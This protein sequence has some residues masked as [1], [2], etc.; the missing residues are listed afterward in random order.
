M[1]STIM[2]IKQERQPYG[3]TDCAAAWRRRGP[4]PEPMIP[5]IRMTPE[6]L[7]GYRRIS[8]HFTGMEF[9]FGGPSGMFAFY[10][11]F[12]VSAE[13][14]V[15]LTSLL[16]AHSCEH[17]A[18]AME[19][20]IRALQERIDASQ[21]A[22]SVRGGDRL[23]YVWDD[24]KLESFSEPT[25]DET[26]ATHLLLSYGDPALYRRSH[27]GS[28][29][30]LRSEAVRPER[31]RKRS[32]EYYPIRPG[33]SP[34]QAEAVGVDQL[35]RRIRGKPVVAFTGAGLSASAGIP[36]FNGPGG[37]QE[38]VPIDDYRF[39]GAVAS[40]MIDRPHE[41]ATVLGR[42]HCGF[43]TATPNGAHSALAE[44]E[45]ARILTHTITGNFDLLHERAGSEKVHVNERKYFG[46]SSEG[47]DWV[48][49]AQV[50]LVVGVSMDA[51]NGLLDYAR[52]HGLQLVVV[53]PGRPPF[54]HAQDWFVAGRAEDV[55]P[56]LARLL[57]Q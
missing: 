44:L 22:T 31:V 48:R 3:R 23:D 28:N 51:D 46:E 45:R 30:E 4:L 49:A 2:P 6:Q 55:L 42:F 40:W 1:P 32:R 33:R 5:L 25:R 18:D 34:G 7:D 41:T 53:A 56:E 38:E 20:E 43:M 14:Q 21:W 35:A 47:W 26:V 11:D 37:I 24:F 12:D 8:G 50:A 17:G 10:G 27:F 36:A 15:G 19:A 54:M 39:P 13:G 57:T 52:D 9:I 29:F 16:V